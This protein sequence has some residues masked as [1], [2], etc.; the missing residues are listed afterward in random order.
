[1]SDV[2]AW[3]WLASPTRAAAERDLAERLIERAALQAV[4][5]DGREVRARLAARAAARWHERRS[6]ARTGLGR[7]LCAWRAQRHRR[8]SDRLRRAIEGPRRTPR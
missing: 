5:V 6:V 4:L 2:A 3:P 1:M 8:K 7:R